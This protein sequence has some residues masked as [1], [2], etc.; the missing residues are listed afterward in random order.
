MTVNENWAAFDYRRLI[1]KLAF[2]KVSFAI[3]ERMALVDWDRFNLIY[4]GP[5]LVRHQMEAR[6]LGP[7]L[8]ALGNLITEA[9]HKLNDDRAF[10]KVFVDS[11]MKPGSFS[12]ALEVWQHLSDHAVSASL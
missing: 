1:Q 5:A 10:V 6:E 3:R 8:L 4:D 7:A 9:N 11:E 2:N 12:V